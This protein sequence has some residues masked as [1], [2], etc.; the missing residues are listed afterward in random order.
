MIFRSGRWTADELDG[1]IR[2]AARIQGPGER[3]A[4]ISGHFLG[5]PYRESTLIGD[6]HIPEN[7]V[8]DLGGMDCFT[9]LDYVDAIRMSSS[10]H[11]FAVV[12]QWVRYHGGVVTY[13][14]RNHF[15]TGWTVYN[16]GFVTDVTGEIGHGRAVGVQKALNRRADGSFWLEGIEPQ[17][18]TIT[19]IPSAAVDEAVA[20]SLRTGDYAGIY[21]EKEGLDVSHVG[22]IIRQQDA[23][24]LRHA[25]SAPDARAVIDQDF[26]AYMK[27]R[28]GLIVLRPLELPVKI[29]ECT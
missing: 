24:F 18:R 25:S 4:F 15:F 7:L 11:D 26:L 28:P 21:S 17:A 2:Q 20:T 6:E 3:I 12:L 13:R 10:L 5:I 8:I 27:G 9:F 23:L 19:F 14:T 1:L 22:I 16:T 29:S